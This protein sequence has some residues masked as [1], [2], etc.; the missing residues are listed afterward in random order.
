MI[1]NLL[2]NN[3]IFML[4]YGINRVHFLVAFCSMRMTEVESVAIQVTE[5]IVFASYW[6]IID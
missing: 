2:M 1:Y 3:F 5:I 4:L 6:S